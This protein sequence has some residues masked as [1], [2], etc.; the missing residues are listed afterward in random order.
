VNDIETVKVAIEELVKLRK[1]FTGRDVL[2]RIWNKRVKRDVPLACALP[3]K[4]VSLIVR[5]LFNNGDAVFKDYGS[6]LTFPLTGP[7]L[8]FPMPYHAKKK[9]QAIAEHFKPAVPVASIP[10]VLSFPPSSPVSNGRSL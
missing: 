9:A 6:S 10:S 5:R 1:S 7:I 8:F 2:E 3:E 4:Q